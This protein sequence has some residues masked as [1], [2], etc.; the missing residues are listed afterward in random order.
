MRPD[1][2]PPVPARPLAQRLG[3]IL[4]P[5]F[6]AAGIATMVCFAYVDPVELHAI[7]F[8]GWRLSRT[9]GYTIGFFMFWAVTAASSLGTWLLLRSAARI[10]A[11]QPDDEPPGRG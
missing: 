4:W 7:S 9:A 6:L 3:A 11:A 1:E 10:N 8:P 5:S 2:L